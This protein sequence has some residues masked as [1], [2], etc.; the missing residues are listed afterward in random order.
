MEECPVLWKQFLLPSQYC[1]RKEEKSLHPTKK[2][3]CLYTD[4]TL[5]PSTAQYSPQQQSSVPY[6]LLSSF[7]LLLF[8]IPGFLLAILFL[9]KHYSHFPPV[10]RT[11][12]IQALFIS[13]SNYFIIIKV[14]VCC[15]FFHAFIRMVS[16]QS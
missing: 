11:F 1:N 15:W 16:I 3:N 5:N 9:K 6:R 8:A 7:L 14:S 10:L 13:I 2:S 4:N 12:G